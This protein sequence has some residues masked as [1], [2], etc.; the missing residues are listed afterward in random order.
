MTKL[1]LFVINLNYS[2]D[3]SVWNIVWCYVNRFIYWYFRNK[4]FNHNI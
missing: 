1:Q 4:L 3:F 2:V